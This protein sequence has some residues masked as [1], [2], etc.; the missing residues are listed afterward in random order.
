MKMVKWEGRLK[1]LPWTGGTHMLLT[2]NLSHAYN[3]LKVKMMLD[4]GPSFT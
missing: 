1:L 4:D 2:R 3:N